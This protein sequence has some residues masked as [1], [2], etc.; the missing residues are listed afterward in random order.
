MMELLVIAVLFFAFYGT[1]QVGYS[2]GRLVQIDK[3]VGSMS[4]Q[5]AL[6]MTTAL[7]KLCEFTEQ[8]AND[9]IGMHR[10]AHH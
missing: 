4:K 1:Y 9:K 5:D 8:V 3:L 2:H 6:R 7:E 10:V